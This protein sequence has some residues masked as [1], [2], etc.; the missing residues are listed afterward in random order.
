MLSG[1]RSE[2]YWYFGTFNYRNVSLNKLTEE[3]EGLA[4]PKIAEH[5][6]RF[7]KT[8]PGEYGEGDSFVGI[9]VPKLREVAKRYRTVSRA[10]TVTL[11]KSKYHEYR[12]IALVILVDH[13][14]RGNRQDRQAICDLYL[15]HTEFINNWDL[16]DGS[17][18]QIV[19]GYF[20][21]RSRRPLL[22]LAKSRNLWERRIAILATLHFIRQDD[23]DSTL[24][25][26]ELLLDDPED[27]M[28]KA[29]GWMLR[30]AWKRQ[31]AAVERFLRA[32]YN[33]LP[34]TTLRYAI[35]RFPE[36]VR[37]AQLNG[38]I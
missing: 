2:T 26:A 10:D 11:L 8:G 14:R 1:H 34:R 27:L 25:I 16:V 30:E 24:E 22:K 19:G 18:P 12:L 38:N 20:S 33:R 6:S 32:H 36:K 35:E 7:F 31:P 17:A 9:R 37:K 21:D 4:D 3:L 28:H 29:V 5:S 15:G 13:S 23:I